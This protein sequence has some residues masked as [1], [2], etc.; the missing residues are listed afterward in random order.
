M[1]TFSDSA[2][3]IAEHVAPIFRNMKQLD[4]Y[5][6]K[7]QMRHI[8]VISSGWEG[9][10][11]CETEKI[12]EEAEARGQEL[13]DKEIEFKR[14]YYLK[15][16]SIMDEELENASFENFRT[17]TARQKEVLA[18]AKQMAR[19]YYEGGKGNVIM[20]GEAGRGKSHLAYGMVKALSDTTKKTATLVNVLDLLAEIKSDFSQEQFWMRTLSDV[21]YLVLDDLGAERISDWSKGIIYSILNKRTS[22]IITTNLSSGDL[23]SA[24][25]KRIMSRILKGCPDEHIMNFAGLE[26]ERR[27]LWQ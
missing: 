12:H 22:T 14:S 27:K 1:M 4:A 6:G 7:H 25:G 15:K 11:K 18:W 8:R 13:A 20:L 17:D 24:Y 5:C 9:C 23:V 10:P 21:D 3:R 2:E 26:D 19:F 16:L